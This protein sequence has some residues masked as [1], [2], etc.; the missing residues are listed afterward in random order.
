MLNQRTLLVTAR[1]WLACALT[2]ALVA[3]IA[4]SAWS[5]TPDEALVETAAPAEVPTAA[6]PSADATPAQ[7][8]V[9]NPESYGLWVLAPAIVAIV[10]AILMRQ[11]VPALFIG[12]IVGAYMLVP[13]RDP[14]T[15]LGDIHIIEGLRQAVETY[16]IGAIAA[17][18]HIHVVLFTLIIGGAVGVMTASGGTRALVNSFTRFASTSRRGQLI[19]WIAGMVVFFDDYANSMIVG[20]TMRPMCDRLKISRAKL[21]YIVDSTAAPIASIALIGTWLGAELGYIQS[22]LDIIAQDGAPEF[23]A[24]ANNMDVFLASIPY[25]FYPIFALWLVVCVA[26]TGRDFGPM[27]RSESRALIESHPDVDDA[28]NGGGIAG[29]R[30][31]AVS[32][33]LAAFPVLVLVGL[34]LAILYRTGR[35]GAGDTTGLS[36]WQAAQAILRNADAY[37][38]ILYGAIGS[39][40]SASV[41]AMLAGA[42]TTRGAFDGMLDGMAKMF[43]A[44]VILILA[45]ALSQISQD[46]ALGAVLKQHI[47]D[48]DLG[49]NWLPIT[50]WLPISVF[51][52]AALVS[53]AT[54]SSWTTMGIM[55]AAVVET[56]AKLA[57]DM[58]P[59]QAPQF[60][61]AAV[62]CVLAGSIFGDHCSPISDTTV[63]SAVASSCR[64]EEHVWTQLPYAVVTAIVAMGAG[65]AYCM[66]ESK[67]A[68]M[69]LGIGAVALFLI[70]V[71]IGRRPKAPP[72]V[73]TIPPERMAERLAGDS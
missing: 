19:T 53:F 68:W 58:P 6:D 34:T 70:V 56:S 43:P 24:E 57:M 35:A 12:I 60:F 9:E 1:R 16:L 5:Q 40:A 44:I 49:I 51:I 52:C 69:G 41:L 63:L 13:C 25:R 39:L 14:A 46:L 38:S 10:L 18:D 2:F 4:S 42:C 73:I 7:T 61:Y 62:G 15:H 33:W 23:L 29:T 50:V 65:I 45:W 17:T 8:P 22:G 48:T 71:I 20:P 32:A 72:V 11:A 28:P 27:R 67:P 37:L 66:H 3:S 36:A 47:V 31:K 30:T 64:V 26:L 59:D 21:A 55:T 54:G